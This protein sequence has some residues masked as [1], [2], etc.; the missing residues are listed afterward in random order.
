MIHVD[1][2]E[3]ISMCKGMVVFE[4]DF[5]NVWSTKYV[6]NASTGASAPELFAALVSTFITRSALGLGTVVGSLV[7]P[8]DKTFKRLTSDD[9]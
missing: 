5:F 3:I 8:L 1:A 4:I 6:I 9:K 2:E 7:S